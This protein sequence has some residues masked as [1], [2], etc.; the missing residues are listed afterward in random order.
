M[1]PGR[2]ERQMEAAPVVF[3]FQRIPAITPVV[4]TTLQGTKSIGLS[5]RS[6]GTV[7]KNGD[8]YIDA[9][10]SNLR[11]FMF[12]EIK[13]KKSPLREFVE[14]LFDESYDPDNPPPNE[15][16]IVHP[17]RLKTEIKHAIDE[18]LKDAHPGVE[19]DS[20]DLVHDEIII[21]TRFRSPPEP[22][23][24]LEFDLVPPEAED[25]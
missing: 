12:G 2:I 15:Q 10:G 5:V 17:S 23:F 1:G 7:N 8:L 20:V 11:K 4:G 16:T 3:P 14:G 18:A 25:A 21:Q 13:P 9:F 19:V 22:K 6:E 24:V